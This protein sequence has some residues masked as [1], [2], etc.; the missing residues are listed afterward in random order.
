MSEG[1][2][3]AFA[4]RLWADC[5]RLRARWVPG[6]G[7][8]WSWSVVGSGDIDDFSAFSGLGILLSA[9]AVSFTIRNVI[10]YIIRDISIQMG[11]VNALLCCA[12]DLVCS[13]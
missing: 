13:L 2:Y 4:P 5:R 10:P 12:A 11:A 1:W 6:D 8:G 3:A 7:G 9:S